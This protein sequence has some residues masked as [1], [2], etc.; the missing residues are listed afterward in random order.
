MSATYRAFKKL[1]ESTWKDFMHIVG[2]EDI[3]LK[4]IIELEEF[5]VSQATTLGDLCEIMHRQPRYMSIS[6]TPPTSTKCSYLE[7]F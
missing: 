2:N 4:T 3:D 5:T 1:N 6:R 7:L